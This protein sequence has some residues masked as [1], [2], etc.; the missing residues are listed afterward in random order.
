MSEYICILHK[1]FGF[2]FLF[3]WSKSFLVNSERI[4]RVSPEFD[5][6]FFLLSLTLRNKSP[7]EFSLSSWRNVNPL[8]VV[9]EFHP[10]FWFVK[11]NVQSHENMLA[12]NTH[13]VKKK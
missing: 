7:K 5:F 4:Q 11:G 3:V 10:P 13:S 12:K 6:F 2:F 1:F 9:T 8:F